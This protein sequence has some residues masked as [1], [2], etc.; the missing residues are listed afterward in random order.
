MPGISAGHHLFFV[1]AARLRGLLFAVLLA[2]LL[3]ALT[4]VLAL[5]LAALAV[6]G[7]LRV[8]LTHVALVSAL[9]LFAVAFFFHAA[10]LLL[11]TIAIVHLSILL[12]GD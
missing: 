9:L 2:L 10:A 8:A 1:G 7:L 11:T 5:M 12:F 4:R 6:C 3:S